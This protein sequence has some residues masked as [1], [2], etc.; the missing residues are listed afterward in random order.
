M[1]CEL[2]PKTIFIPAN[3]YVSSVSPIYVSRKP[4]KHDVRKIHFVRAWIEHPSRDRIAP[5]AEV[6]AVEAA[7]S[8]AFEWTLDS[9]HRIVR[10]DKTSLKT[11]HR[12]EMQNI[13]HFSI[14]E[15][16][17][18]WWSNFSSAFQSFLN[19]RW[20][21]SRN[22]PR[23]SVILVGDE[24]RGREGRRIK[25]LKRQDEKEKVGMSQWDVTWM[26]PGAN[27][28]R[29]TSDIYAIVNPV[30]LCHKHWGWCLH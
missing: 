2:F 6:F 25:G 3:I 16:V 19:A 23:W 5:R 11:G 27:P 20:T 12:A 15:R 24:T 26:P 7:R 22:W 8:N 21:K 30:K 4:R 14:V 13:H 18:W 17:F 10:M 28:L 9:P 29:G 1:F